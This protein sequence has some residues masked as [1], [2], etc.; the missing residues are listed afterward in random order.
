[1]WLQ[2]LAMIL[3]IIMLNAIGYVALS[4]GERPFHAINKHVN[5]VLGWA[6]AIATMMANLVWCMPQF[7]L[8]TDAIQNNLA[9]G[10]LGK[11]AGIDP[12]VA[13]GI[14]VAIL[15]VIGGTVVWFYDS[16]AKGVKIFEGLLKLMVGVVVISF[17]GVVVKMSLS[18][19][20]L[21]WGEIGAGFVPD[22]SLLFS[23]ALSPL[24]PAS[25]MPTFSTKISE[26]ETSMA[27]FPIWPN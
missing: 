9:P 27:S 4:T 18:G 5:P 10:L 24:S 12:N 19:S 7:A 25:T 16:G 14:C 6:W 3:G 2:P 20:G 1:M 23:P 26:P 17:F 11:G 22:L 15:F 13:N 21:N 8:G